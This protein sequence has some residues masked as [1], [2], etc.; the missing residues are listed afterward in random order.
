MSK[1]RILPA[2][3]ECWRMTPRA[4]AV[5][6]TKVSTASD[7][8]LTAFLPVAAAAP[9]PAAAPAAVPI[10]A[11]F[12][13]PAIAPMTAPNAAPPPIFVALLLAWDSPLITR[14]LTL[15]EVACL[16]GA[17]RSQ[18]Q[19]QLSRFAQPAR[20]MHIGHASNDV[21]TFGI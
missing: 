9:V 18:N 16:P 6:V 5:V 15:R 8:T 19:I 1:P 2:G 7:S 14:G 20:C 12:P 11:P 13:P 17:H 4:R 3:P 21:R 10:A